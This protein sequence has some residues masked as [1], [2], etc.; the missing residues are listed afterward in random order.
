MLLTKSKEDFYIR[1][2]EYYWTPM[3]YFV[4]SRL[5]RKKLNLSNTHIAQE[6]ARFYYHKMVMEKDIVKENYKHPE[7]LSEHEL[8]KAQQK[9]EFYAALMR[10]TVPGLTPLDKAINLLT[11]ISKKKG[12]NMNP[13]GMSEKDLSEVFMNVPDDKLM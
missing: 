3:E 9:E 6:L 7:E 8:E 11:L 5:S 12:G 13:E 1:E 2:H 4:Q 10:R